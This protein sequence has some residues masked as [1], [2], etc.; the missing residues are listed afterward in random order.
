M[1]SNNDAKKLKISQRDL[2]ISLKS[3]LNLNLIPSNAY[4]Y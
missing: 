3:Y 4:E 2:I 1:F